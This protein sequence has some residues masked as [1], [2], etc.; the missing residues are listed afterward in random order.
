MAASPAAE[1]RPLTERQEFEQASSLYQRVFHYTEQFTLNTKLMRSL[2]Y[3]GG[4]AVGAFSDEKVLIGFVYGFPAIDN[5]TPYLFSQ[6]ACVDA[7]WQGRGVGR[8]LKHA[9]MDQARRGGFTSMRWPYDPM[10]TRNA[11]FNLSRL[12]ARARWFK[13]DFYDDG[14][15]DRLIVEWDGV[16]WDGA[17]WNGVEW[18]GAAKDGSANQPVIT[19]SI[20][21]AP[22]LFGQVQQLDASRAAI[23]LPAGPQAPED[24]RPLV[25][26][27]LRRVLEAGYAA[28]QCVRVAPGVFAYLCQQDSV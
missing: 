15:S 20:D 14:H 11:F 5:A 17:E 23:T 22:A 24:T 9:Q 25:A 28:V 18:N 7:E 4:T 8:A 10:N 1:L 21:S 19:A 16:E 3:A 13:P 26:G 12:G 2:M 6:A 27:S